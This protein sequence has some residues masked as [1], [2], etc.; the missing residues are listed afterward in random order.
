[1][2]LPSKVI[3][4]SPGVWPGQEDSPRSARPTEVTALL[5]GVWPAQ[6]VIKS[7]MKRDTT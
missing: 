5:P 6:D 7:V 3:T 1:M 4:L 2:I